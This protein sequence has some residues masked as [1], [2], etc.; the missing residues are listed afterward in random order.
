MLLNLVSF[1]GDHYS[2][3]TMGAVEF[4]IFLGSLGTE[5][6]LPLVFM[7]EPVTH[8]EEEAGENSGPD[9]LLAV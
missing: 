9:S 1:L 7:L 8:T 6:A 4:C 2:Y 5:G 3:E